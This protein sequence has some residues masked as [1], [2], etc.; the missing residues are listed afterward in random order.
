VLP[1]LLLTLR[2]PG[3][4]LA[5][6]GAPFTVPAFRRYALGQ[7]VASFGTWIQNITQDWLVLTLTHSAT[8]VGLTAAFQFLPALLLGTHGGAMADRLPRRRMLVIAQTLNCAVAATTAT[9]TLTSHITAQG[10]YVLAVIAGLIWVIDNPTRQ[11]LLGDVVPAERLSSAVAVNASI[12][13]SARVVAPALAGAVITTFGA[14]AALAVD[15]LFFAIALAAWR[16][17]PDSPS[18]AAAHDTGSV[19]LPG[20]LRYVRRRPPLALTIL[21]VGLVGT[22]G[23]NFPVVLTV[24]AQENFHGSANLYGLFNVMLAIGSVTGALI[25]AAQ[26]RTELTRIITLAALFGLTQALTAVMPTRPS[27]LL[28]LVL[29]GTVNLLFQSTANAAVQLWTSTEWR[30]RVLGLYGQLFVGG[31]PIGA[32]LIGALTERFGGRAGM[33][34]CGGI[35]LTGALL[36]AAAIA[37]RR[38][39][40]VA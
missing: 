23:L 13:Q 25:A 34:L 18:P 10:I 39:S 6:A 36:L 14:G 8:A 35:P 37:T 17:V 15:T 38:E 21:L 3:A 33:A 9:L 2:R 40:Q 20:V 12:F 16:R 26:P 27:F 29:L 32:P 4:A 28:L 19:G 22:F 11:A 1:T 24:I 30:G 5:R 7:G 31:T